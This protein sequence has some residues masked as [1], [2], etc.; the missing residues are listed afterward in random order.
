[1][2]KFKLTTLIELS[3]FAIALLIYGNASALP[4]NDT[5]PEELK[6]NDAQYQCLQFVTKSLDDPRGVKF[7]FFSYFPVK[8]EKDGIYNITVS[9]ADP[10]KPKTEC[11]IKEAS[12]GNWE[13]LSLKAV[14]P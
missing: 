12:P 11:R 7:G 14:T 3:I 10:S 8:I 2:L 9:F 5:S 4:S 1:M 6:K 13:L